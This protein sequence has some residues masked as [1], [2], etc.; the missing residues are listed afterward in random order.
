MV[1]AILGIAGTLLEVTGKLI[2]R[3]PDY[4]QKKRE[5]FLALKRRYDQVLVAEE[6]NTNLLLNL[7]DE[8]AN[9]AEIIVEEL[10]REK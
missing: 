7:R 3:S 5:E 2:D 9:F 10:N 4:V 8:I 1:P 6:K